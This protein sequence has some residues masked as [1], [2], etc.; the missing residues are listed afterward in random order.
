MPVSYLNRRSAELQS[1]LPELT[2]RT[3]FDSFWEEMLERFRSVPLTPAL[4]TVDY[5]NR[6]LR[7]LDVADDCFDSTRIH[8]SLIRSVA[9]AL[10]VDLPGRLRAWSTTTASAARVGGPPTSPRERSWAWRCLRSTCVT[11]VGRPAAHRDQWAQPGR[12]HREHR[13]KFARALETLSHFDTMN[14]A[15]RVLGA[16]S[17]S[18][19]SYEGMRSDNE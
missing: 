5:P 18:P 7:V 12:R 9:A 10:F 2:R 1:Y 8:R 4:D 14:I 16:W 6:R 19:A 13:G 15:D 11:C 17:G 3:D